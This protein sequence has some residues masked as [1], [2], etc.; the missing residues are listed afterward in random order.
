MARSPITLPFF[1]TAVALISMK[2]ISPLLFMVLSQN[3]WVR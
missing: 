3:E 1:L 2:A